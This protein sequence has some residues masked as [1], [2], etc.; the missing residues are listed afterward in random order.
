M[1]RVKRIDLG[2]LSYWQM[3]IKSCLTKVSMVHNVGLIDVCAE[4]TAWIT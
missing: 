4:N 2:S 3:K 1:E